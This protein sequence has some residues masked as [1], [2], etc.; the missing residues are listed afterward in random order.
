MIPGSLQADG[1]VIMVADQRVGRDR[2]GRLLRAP[3]AMTTADVSATAGETSAAARDAETGRVR[4]GGPTALRAAHPAPRPRPRRPAR[5]RGRR[6]GRI[7]VGVPVLGP[8]RRD[9][10]PG[11]ALHHRPAP[12]VQP[13][14]R[15]AALARGDRPDRAASLDRSLG[16]GPVGGPRDASTRARDPRCCSTCST[17]TP[18]RRSPRMLGYRKGRSRAGSRAVGRPFAGSSIRA[19][20][21]RSDAR[22]GRRPVGGLSACRVE[23]EAHHEPPS[24]VGRVTTLIIRSGDVAC[25]MPHPGQSRGANPCFVS[26]RS[27][28]P[29]QLPPPRI[30]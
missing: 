15:P 27:G 7:P 5:R 4:G 9:R 25:D 1:T 20:S 8:L 22:A 26:A 3:D 28:S 24:H 16:P 6:P 10:R 13:P 11:L 17:A 30:R 14:P 29:P 18:R 2:C 12:G 19:A 23:R 21:R